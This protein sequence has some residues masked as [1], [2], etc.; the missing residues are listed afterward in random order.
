MTKVKKIFPLGDRVLVKPI[1]TD[2][3]A[4]KTDSGII[5][6]DTVSKEKPEQGKVLAIGEGRYD[7]GKLIKP[8]VK[9]GDRVLFSKYGYDEIKIEDE[10]LF[11]IKEEN[12]LAIIK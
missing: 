5:I 9:E 4:T 12:I 1:D 7:D 8:R 6:P 10:E 11:I 3:L 2:E